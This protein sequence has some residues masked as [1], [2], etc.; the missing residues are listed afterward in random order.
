MHV[1]INHT[2]SSI[3]QHTLFD[4]VSNITSCFGPHSKVHFRPE[5]RHTLRTPLGLTRLDHVDCVENTLCT[6]RQHIATLSKRIL[7]SIVIYVLY[8]PTEEDECRAGLS[9]CEQLCFNTYTGYNC[10]CQKGYKLNGKYSCRGK[11]DSASLLTT[12]SVIE[13]YSVD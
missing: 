7:P 3:K 2:S 11:T 9:Q 10:G 4:S 6:S 5:Q 8:F 12:V 1:I 13:I